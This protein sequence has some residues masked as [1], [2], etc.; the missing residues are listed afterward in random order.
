[1]SRG[2]IGPYRS[3]AV[4]KNSLDVAY[5]GFGVGDLMRMLDGLLRRFSEPDEKAGARTHQWRRTG[6]TLLL[7]GDK[8]IE[9]CASCHSYRIKGQVEWEREGGEVDECPGKPSYPWEV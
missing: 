5:G 7:S 4:E 3:R 1:M 6:I 8:A 9:R 2:T